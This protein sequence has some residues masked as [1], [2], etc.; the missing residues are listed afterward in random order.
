MTTQKLKIKIIVERLDAESKGEKW[1]K[2]M[3]NE[4]IDQENDNKDNKSVEKTDFT[5]CSH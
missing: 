2:G 4:E 1:H 5:K 3:W